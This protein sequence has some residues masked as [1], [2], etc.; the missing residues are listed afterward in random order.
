MGFKL[1]QSP[2][3][4]A[5]VE[6]EF[7]AERG[8]RQTARFDVQFPRMTM[9]EIEALHEWIRAEQADDRRI[10]RRLVKDWRGVDAED[11]SPAAFSE[12]ALEALLNLGFGSAI[13]IAFFNNLPKA[14]AKN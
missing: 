13:C 2:M 6:A 7:A 14:K 5:T 3:F 1:A 8:G 9:D 10:A 12:D 11:G 4:W